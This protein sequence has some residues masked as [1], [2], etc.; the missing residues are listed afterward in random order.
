[1]TVREDGSAFLLNEPKDSFFPML[2]RY[3]TLSAAHWSRVWNAG[4]APASLLVSWMQ[5]WLMSGAGRGARAEI[6]MIG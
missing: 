3:K 5:M 2:H 4:L 1:M 6:Q